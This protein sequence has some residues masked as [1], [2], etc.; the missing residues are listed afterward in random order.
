MSAR[1]VAD[2]FAGKTPRRL[3]W[4]PELNEGFVRKLLNAPPGTPGPYWE[5]EREAARRIG[6]DHLHRVQTVRTIHRRV[7]IETDEATGLCVIRTPAG[8]LSRRRVWDANSGTLLNYELLVKGPESFA[9]Y[10]AMLDDETYE[11]SPPAGPEAEIAGSD[12]ATIDVPATPL[13]HLIMWDMGVQETLMCM[14]E[15]TDELVELC[16]FAHEK[17]K[18]FYAVACSGPGR[19]I[20]P[21]E[22]TS[23]MLTGPRMYAEHCVWQL[24]EYA[25]IVRRAGKL[26][27]PHMC[28]HLGAKMLEVIAQIDLDGIEAI[29]P[30]PLG[31]ADLPAMRRALGD[32]VWLIGGVDPSRY[33]ICT[34]DEMRTHVRATLDRMRGDRHFVLGHEEIPLAAKLENVAVVAELVEQTADGFYS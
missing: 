6:A 4:A 5:L 1:E 15:H 14:L 22:D 16:R 32:D 23:S 2:L 3:P 29:T 27:V 17:N 31:D 11:L 18:Q 9:A 24:N 28:G 7:E 12:L 21:M 30:P 13:Q 10:R 8:D 20:R 25:A 19:I 34:P 33:A 26:F